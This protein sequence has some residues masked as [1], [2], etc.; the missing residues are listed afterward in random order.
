VMY[1]VI[2]FR[3]SSISILKVFISVIY[4]IILLI[5]IFLSGKMFNHTLTFVLEIIEK[6]LLKMERGKKKR[7]KEKKKN[8]CFITA[9]GLL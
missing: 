2:Y 3:I 8:K 6:T 5:Q 9:F 7:K 4:S 1:L